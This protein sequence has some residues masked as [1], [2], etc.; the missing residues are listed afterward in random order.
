MGVETLSKED[1]IE[2]IEAQKQEGSDCPP[3]RTDEA[4]TFVDKRLIRIVVPI[5]ISPA[6]SDTE[7]LRI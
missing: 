4:S 5:A 6:I 3:A 7:N 1:A 2:P